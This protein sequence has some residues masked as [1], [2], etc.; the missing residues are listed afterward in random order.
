MV[1]RMEQGIRS[2]EIASQGQALEGVSFGRGRHVRL[3][4]GGSWRVETQ[5]LGNTR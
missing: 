1:F 3:L 2:G 5:E 4:L